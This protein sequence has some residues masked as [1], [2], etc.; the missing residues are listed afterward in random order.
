MQRKGLITVIPLLGVMVARR[1][2]ASK[3]ISAEPRA[4]R[5][6]RRVPGVSGTVTG[7]PQAAEGASSSHLGSIKRSDGT[8][9]VTYEGHPLYLFI[10]DK[11]DGDIY[12][13]GNPGPASAYLSSMA[14]P[15]VL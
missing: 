7:K 8:T 11:D 12:G 10:R 14:L 1:A 9:Q 3:R 2:G 5:A 6:P 15:D 4:T 13:Q